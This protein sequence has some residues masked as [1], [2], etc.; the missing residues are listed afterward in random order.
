MGIL[1][2]SVSLCRYRLVGA[3]RTRPS[4]NRLSGL[5][6]PHK[7]GPVTLSGIRKEERIGWV[8]PSNGDRT[9]PLAPDAPWDMSDCRTENGFLL[10]WRRE[11]R[12][13]P[14][15]LLSLIYRQRFAAESRGGKPPGPK[16]RQE[17]REKT[18][19]EL[20][21]KA[22]PTLAYTDVFWRDDGE[23][24]LFGAG[25]K[26]REGFEK[27]FLATFVTPLGLAMV[28]VDPPLL[29]LGEKHW[30]DSDIAASALRR[31][32]STTPSAFV[33]QR[34]T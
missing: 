3:T 19:E 7:A 21:A 4:L 6:D 10:R 20:L 13:V 16:A 32:S 2:G 25:K 30:E 18:R 5:V 27:L 1:Q 28:R 15:S 22:L 17:L 29:G 24:I 23:V 34:Q 26:T 8:C 33:E 12:R 31:L 11:T 9:L 14:S